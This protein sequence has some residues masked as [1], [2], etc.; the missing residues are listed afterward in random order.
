MAQNGPI[1][2]A[3]QLAD[4]TALI[5]GLQ[6]EVTTL[7]QENLTLT[8]ANSALTGQV[9]TVATAA[10]AAPGG[11][12]TAAGAAPQAAIMFATTPAM[13]RHEDIIDYSSKMGYHDI[14]RRLSSQDQQIDL[15]N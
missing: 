2:I 15:P 6:G 3:Q 7:R 10:M 8:N 5:T 14:Q 13:L 1:D 11:P 4:L 9:N 12:A